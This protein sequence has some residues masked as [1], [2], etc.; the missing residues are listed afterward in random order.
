VDASKKFKTT[1]DSHFPVPSEIVPE[2][3]VSYPDIMQ[4]TWRLEVIDRAES[5]PKRVR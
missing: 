2:E 5:P 4:G 3:N 1:V